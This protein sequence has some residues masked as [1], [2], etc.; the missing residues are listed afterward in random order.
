MTNEVDL[1][2]YGDN[3]LTDD[4]G[5]MAEVSCDEIEVAEGDSVESI[6]TFYT[7]SQNEIKGL[8]FTTYNG[9][10][11]LFGTDNSPDW[12]AAYKEDNFND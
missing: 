11:K 2:S 9:H 6:G 4:S 1:E 8:R 12:E 10:S 7:E 3:E 5:N